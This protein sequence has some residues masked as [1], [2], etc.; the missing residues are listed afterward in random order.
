MEDSEDA[1]QDYIKQCYKDNYYYYGS[2]LHHN[3]YEERYDSRDGTAT[4]AES[5]EDY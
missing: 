4:E 5:Y 1:Y 3:P 2:I